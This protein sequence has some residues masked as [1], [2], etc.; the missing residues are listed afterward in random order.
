MYTDDLLWR[1]RQCRKRQRNY[2]PNFCKLF[3]MVLKVIRGGVFANYAPITHIAYLGFVLDIFGIQT[4]K[5]S[6]N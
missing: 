4:D 6:K 5:R 3:A 1:N 2:V